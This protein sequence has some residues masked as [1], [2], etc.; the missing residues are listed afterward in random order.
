MNIVWH[1]AKRNACHG[2]QAVWPALHGP[3]KAYG[4]ARGLT[5]IAAV[6]SAQGVKPAQQPQG[7]QH[8]VLAVQGT[9]PGL[10]AR[11][12]PPIRE[13]FSFG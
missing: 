10:P 4:N 11:D 13:L 3:E 12:N 9:G 5:G 7:L 1:A 8:A 2:A 6:T